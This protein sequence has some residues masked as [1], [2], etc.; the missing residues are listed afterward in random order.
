[1]LEL[2]KLINLIFPKRCLSV[3]CE[4]ELQNDVLRSN[5]Y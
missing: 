2:F 1:M 3:Q 4:K 5:M